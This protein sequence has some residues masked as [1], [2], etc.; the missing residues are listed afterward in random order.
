MNP[1]HHCWLRVK[2]GIFNLTELLRWYWTSFGCDMVSLI[3][4]EVTLARVVRKHSVR[5]V[6]STYFHC[7]FLR[8]RTIPAGHTTV[9][10]RFQKRSS[11]TTICPLNRQRYTLLNITEMTCSG[12]LSRN[13]DPFCNRV[14]LWTALHCPQ[15]TYRH[16]S[17]PCSASYI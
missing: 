16:Y 3:N 13:L 9:I 17:S 10:S 12:M 6:T 7:E 8:I 11:D 2:N 1:L 5:S 14:G 15:E 4:L